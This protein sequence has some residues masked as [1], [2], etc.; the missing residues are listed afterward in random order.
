MRLLQ[1]TILIGFFTGLAISDDQWDGQCPAD[2]FQCKNGR[3]ITLAWKCDLQDDCHDNSDE[4]GCNYPTCT[5]DYFRCNS[6]K[7]IPERWFCDGH[8]DCPDNSDEDVQQC[9]KAKCPDG[10]FHC[11]KSGKCISEDWKCDGEEN[12]PD[13]EDEHGCVRKCAADEFTCTNGKCISKKFQCDKTDDC[14][15]NSDEDKDICG[16]GDCSPDHHQ[17]SNG[18]CIHDIWWCDEDKDCDDGSD[19][20]NCTSK[21]LPAGLC[22][23]T[24]FQCVNQA[25]DFCID[26]NWVCDGDTDCLDG[27]DEENCA[28]ITCK[29]GERLCVISNYCLKEEYFCDGEKD[30][31]E[32]DDE[33]NCT[34]VPV[35]CEAGHFDCKNG[36]CIK[37]HKVCDGTDDC[38]NGQ[39]E[40]TGICP[41]TDENP[42]LKDNGG[43]AQICVP[44]KK[45][46]TGRRCECDAGY[47]LMT[48]SAS[49]PGCEDIDECQIPGT[50][51]QIC[52]NTKG[53]YKCECTS[54]FSLVEKRYCKAVTRHNAELFLSDR[55]ELRRYHLSSERYSLLQ[56]DHSSG[57]R[58][59][60]LDVRNGKVYWTDM[61]DEGKV[62]MF[63]I[64]TQTKEVLVQGELENPEGMAL[65]WVH[66]NLYISDR[67]KKTIQVVQIV[68]KIRKTLLSDLTDP[69][70]VAADP[71]KGWIYW[72]NYGEN[73]VIERSGM[74]GANR[75]TIISKSL[76]WPQGLTIDHYSRRL[77][78]VDAKLHTISSSK[79]DGSDEQVVL[80]SHISLPHP[81][82]V[83]LFED[84]VFWTDIVTDS[85]FKTR[86][87]GNKSIEVLA[88]GLKRPMAIQVMHESRQPYYPDLNRCVNNGGCS[89]FCLP[90][91]MS[92]GDELRTAECACPDNMFLDGKQICVDGVQPKI[93]IDDNTTVQG[94]PNV[95]YSGFKPN[96]TTERGPSGSTISS[97]QGVNK[98]HKGS[99][100]GEGQIALVAIGVVALIG[101]VAV[102]VIVL[103]VRRHK[104]RNVRSM[105]FDNP[106]YRKTTTDDQ[107]IVG[108]AQPGLPQ[109]M[110]PLNE[111]EVV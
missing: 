95:P 63:D 37:D 17:C 101:L 99:S 80:H 100:K 54:G 47:K 48:S 35:K 77:Y 1:L 59:I 68:K 61:Q 71:I 44:D 90:V 82:G 84:Y 6:G 87:F 66:H 51:S 52:T 16:S 57:S 3:C 107:L 12:C 64:K 43:C 13:G 65:D 20:A 92:E 56:E 36:N 110:Q 94:N 76:S 18:D 91:P 28:S 108:T 21:Q 55:N 103:L 78:W 5:D 93:V 26:K 9:T 83:T 15:D 2:E 34:A 97:N 73:S 69:I 42:C 49:D 45:N 4:Q 46:P 81:Y 38:G 25:E 32:G 74:N 27:S 111:E 58:A 72:T 50:C 89:H 29:P 102:V 86:T 106:V 75:S 70:S 40:S 19:E 24:S 53:S 31:V 8:A 60:D 11:N 67:A 104:K 10:F 14:G 30:C 88:K 96:D 22:D 39:D 98:E 85:V 79:L 41:P 62:N 33:L 105:N 7:C 23:E 109:S